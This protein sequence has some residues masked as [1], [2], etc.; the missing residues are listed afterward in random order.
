MG[1]GDW[2]HKEKYWRSRSK[3]SSRYIGFVEWLDKECE[4]G[5]DVLKIS[6]KFGDNGKLS[7]AWAIFRRRKV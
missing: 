7:Q 3:R 1:E 2:E 6:Q 4:D 5:W